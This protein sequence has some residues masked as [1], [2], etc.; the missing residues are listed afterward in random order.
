MSRPARYAKG[1]AKREEILRKLDFLRSIRLF[2]GIRKRAMIHV[3]ESLQER[4]YLKGETIFAQGDIGRIGPSSTGTAGS[5]QGSSR[6]T[7]RGLVGLGSFGMSRGT[8]LPFETRPRYFSTSASA[9]F[10]SKSPTRATV[11]LFGT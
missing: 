2:E 8:G 6:R 10:V 11:A 5:G 7:R 9:S 3:L 4:T 1:V